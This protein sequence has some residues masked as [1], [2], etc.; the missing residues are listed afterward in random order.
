MNATAQAICLMRIV[1]VIGCCL[2]SS[3]G[4]NHQ[5]PPTESS[6]AVGPT[7]SASNQDMISPSNSVEQANDDT[8]AKMKKVLDDARIHATKPPL[9]NPPTGPSLPPPNY[10]N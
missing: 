1:L 6:E 2:S 5:S 7:R 10:V 9:P 8:I 4:R 3:C